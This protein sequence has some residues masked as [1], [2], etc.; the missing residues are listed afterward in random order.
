VLIVIQDSPRSRLLKTPLADPAYRVL[1]ST[2]SM[3][4]LPASDHRPG[5]TWDP[6]LSISQVLPASLLFRYPAVDVA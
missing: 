2:S 3:T 6:E 1:E 4:R 5:K